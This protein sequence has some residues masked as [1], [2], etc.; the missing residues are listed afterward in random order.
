MD[1]FAARALRPAAAAVF[2]AASLAASL[3]CLFANL[4]ALALARAAFARGDW[5][6][7][8]P[9]GVP[10]VGSSASSSESSSES[11]SAS[12]ALGRPSAPL[13]LLFAK[14]AVMAFLPGEDMV[15]LPWIGWTPSTCFSSCNHAQQARH[16]QQSDP[17]PRSHMSRS[18]GSIGVRSSCTASYAYLWFASTCADLREAGRAATWP[19]SRRATMDPGGPASAIDVDPAWDPDVVEVAPPTPGSRPGESRSDF[20][21]P[22]PPK[23][24]RPSENPTPVKRSGDAANPLNLA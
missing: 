24:T 13:A 3:A 7:G 19:V 16:R 9:I 12:L 11:S 15:Q 22:R 21:H 2:L 6:V 8:P 4:S 1:R 14:A 5:R 23:R 18:S 20:P 17:G 10:P